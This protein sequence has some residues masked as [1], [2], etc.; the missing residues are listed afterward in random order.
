[1][2]EDPE[3][4]LLFGYG[5]WPVAQTLSRLLIDATFSDT[6]LHP[7][8]PIPSVRGKSVLELGVLVAV[9]QRLRPCEFTFS[10]KRLKA[11]LQCAD[12]VPFLQQVFQNTSVSGSPTPSPPFLEVLGWL[13][14]GSVAMPAALKCGSQM[15]ST[16]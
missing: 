6:A 1:M 14:Q 16:A 3:S 10:R 15:V 4:D 7:F 2:D 11:I 9:N 8:H 5:V 12:G 13:W